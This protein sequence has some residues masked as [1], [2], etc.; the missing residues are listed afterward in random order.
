M[1]SYCGAC[2]DVDFRGIDLRG[3][4]FLTQAYKYREP[5]YILCIGCIRV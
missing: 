5:T 3:Y 2:A 1:S 4:T